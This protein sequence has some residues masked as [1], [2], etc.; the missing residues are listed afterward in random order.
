MDLLEE[1]KPVTRVYL[2]LTM[3]C[4]VIHVT[5]LPAPDYFALDISRFYQ[6]WRPFTSVSYLGP[7]SMSMA[8]SLFF[9]LRYGQKLENENGTGP[10]AWFLMT[11][12]LML[13]VLGYLLGFPFQA[14]AMISAIIY[15]CSR[16][17]AMEKM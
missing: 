4:T 1:I 12:T 2:L 5:G 10:F 13:T 7:P 6:I 17:N 15:V 8:N 11:Q 9:L 14:Q 16:V 3:F